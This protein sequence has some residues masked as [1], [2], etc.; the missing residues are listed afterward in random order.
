MGVR[1]LLKEGDR[2]RR[3]ETER[4]I[5][6]KKEEEETQKHS[7]WRDEGIMRRQAG[8]EKNRTEERQEGR[9]WCQV[10]G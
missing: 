4:R 3:R 10:C 9:R 2:E 8:S 6:H 7:H 1:G 5:K